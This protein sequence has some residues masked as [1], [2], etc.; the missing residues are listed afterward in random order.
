MDTFAI[1]SLTIAGFIVGFFNTIAGGATVVSIAILMFL[2]LPATVAN[3]THRIAAAFQTLVSVLVFNKQNILDTKKGI[4]LGIPTTIGS[5]AGAIAAVNVDEQV[6]R[7]F[8]GAAMLLMLVFIFYKPANWLKYDNV[9]TGL[10]ISPF[11]HTLF[12]LIGFYGGF[13]YIGIGYFLLAGLVLSI[14][15]DLVRANALKVFIVL[16]YVPFS[17]IVYMVNGSIN[18]RYALI[19]TLGQMIGA[20]FGA[21]SSTQFGAGFIR[22][23][24]LVFILLTTLQLF[25]IVDLKQIVTGLMNNL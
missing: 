16:L 7:K 8:V 6:F 9:K 2:G 15:Y 14:G 21:K 20:W 19:L 24:M 13:I 17:L 10:K 12:F 22:W 1:I 5:V 3:G 4:R 23:V 25:N 18:Y 11:Q